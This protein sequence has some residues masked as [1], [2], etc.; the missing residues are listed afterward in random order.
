MCIFFSLGKWIKLKSY[1]CPLKWSKSLVARTDILKKYSKLL[2][3][4]YEILNVQWLK[5]YAFFFFSKKHAVEEPQFLFF[6]TGL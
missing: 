3:N 5:G 4:F 1:S 2:G 6:V